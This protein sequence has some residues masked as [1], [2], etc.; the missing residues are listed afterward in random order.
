MKIAIII[1]LLSII[2]PFGRRLQLTQKDTPIASNNIYEQQYQMA[3]FLKQYYQGANVAAND[4]GA[5]NYYADINCLDL[6]GLASNEVLNLIRNNKFNTNNIDEL[7]KNHNTQIAIVYNSW[8][9]QAGGLPKSWHNVGEWTI[10]NNVVC[11]GVTVSFYAVKPDEK[12]KLLQNL[13][14]FSKQL[15]I[16]VIQSGEYTKQ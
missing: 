11:G 14:N 3:L 13:R 6:A 8:Y 2:I 7:T 4:I 10:T 12:D 9:E 16:D 15:P 1:V 5:I